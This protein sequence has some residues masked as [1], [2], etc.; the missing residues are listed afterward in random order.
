MTSLAR[1]ANT[2]I[3][4]SPA[5]IAVTGTVPGTVDLFVFQLDEN[6]QVRSDDDLVFFNNPASLDGTVMLDTDGLVC[7]DLPA[8]SS[9]VS[10]IAV[11]VSLD[12][13]VPGA[14]STEPTLALT[15]SQSG[16]QTITAAKARAG[17]WLPRFG[18]LI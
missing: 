1:G 16:A 8:V 5:T 6:R 7:L 11:A 17:R 13:T 3:A 4:D 12:E 2:A 9:E 10:M 14:L 15:L 18:L